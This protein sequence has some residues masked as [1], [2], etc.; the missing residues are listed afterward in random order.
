MKTIFILMLSVLCYNNNGSS[1]PPTSSTTSA[2]Y[3]SFETAKFAA[4]TH[5]D[6]IEQTYVQGECKVVY[7][8]MEK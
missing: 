3:S 2:E 7:S 4:E 1:R 5:K 8:I 6:Y